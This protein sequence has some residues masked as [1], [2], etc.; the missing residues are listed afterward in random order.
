MYTGTRD[1][2]STETAVARR[3][4]A[5]RTAGGAVA[6]V[7]LLAGALVAVSNPIATA[8]GIGSVA[9]VAWSVRWILDESRTEDDRSGTKRRVETLGNRVSAFV[10]VHG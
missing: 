2:E 5:R 10:G 6:Y 4:A 9:V 3:R 1:P 7:G 8:I